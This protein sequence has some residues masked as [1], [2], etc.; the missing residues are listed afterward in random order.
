MTAKDIVFEVLNSLPDDCTLEDV[1]YQL[2]VK[3]RVQESLEA[4]QRGEWV[5]DEQAR[6]RFSDCLQRF[7]G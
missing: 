2:Y 7:D 3:Q 1:T 4:E 6:E 5:S